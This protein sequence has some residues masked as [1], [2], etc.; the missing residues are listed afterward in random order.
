MSTVLSI[1]TCYINVGRSL[2]ALAGLTIA[3]MGSHLTFGTLSDNRN[4]LVS[5]NQQ[6]ISLQQLNFAAYRLTGASA[7]TLEPEQKK[8]I[9]KLL[10]DEELLLQRA[11][12]LGIASADP[13]IRKALAQT[14]IDQT[15]QEFLDKPITQQQLQ[16]FYR[17]HQSL[18]TQPLRIKLKAYKFD[19]P[20]KTA[21]TLEFDPQLGHQLSMLPES[22]LPVHVL[23]RYLGNR[24]TNIALSL[25]VG[26]TSRPIS[27][28]DGVY[29]L[30]LVAKQ[31]ERPLTFAQARTQIEAEYKRRGRDTALQKKLV[32]LR[33]QADIRINHER[34]AKAAYE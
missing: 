31:P 18:F 3:L 21:Q 16:N 10:I 32:T 9:I 24:L 1:P 8:T 14:V 28:P 6:P 33:Q 5:V 20:A 23:Q 30:H 4:V 15:T 34:H 11:E 13:G 17:R 27:Q 19:K 25:P 26:Q 29:L 7:D 22:L 2:L 12:S